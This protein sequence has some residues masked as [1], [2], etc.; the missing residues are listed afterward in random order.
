MITGE[1]MGWWLAFR[2]SFLVATM[3]LD[4][5]V[6]TKAGL[7]LT[8]FNGLAD[9]NQI[10]TGLCAAHRCAEGKAIM[11][12]SPSQSSQGRVVSLP[13]PAANYRQSENIAKYFIH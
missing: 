1:L 9:F 3:S 4:S 13:V 10:A 5:R 11:G 2:P 12:I 6:S 8:T 7:H